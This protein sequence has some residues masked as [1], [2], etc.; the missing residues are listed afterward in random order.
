[1]IVLHIKPG[2][3]QIVLRW[4]ETSV[5]TFCALALQGLGVLFNY[6]GHATLR[7]ELYYYYFNN[8]VLHC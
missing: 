1:M 4:K 2:V 7:E 3:F 8:V 6:K 5:S